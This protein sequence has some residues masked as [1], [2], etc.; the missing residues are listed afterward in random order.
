MGN[1]RERDLLKDLGV[2]EVDDSKNRSSRS[3]MGTWTGLAWLRIG[4]G[5]GLL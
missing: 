3:G 2:E 4:T 5:G 1:R